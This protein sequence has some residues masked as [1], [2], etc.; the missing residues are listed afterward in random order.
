MRRAVLTW[1]NLTQAYPVPPSVDLS[2]RLTADINTAF[3]LIDIENQDYQKIVLSGVLNV[4]GLNYP[5]ESL[6][7]PLKI[8][9]LN[10]EL[11]PK[12]IEISEI[13]GITGSTD[14]SAVGELQ[15]TLGFL[16]NDGVLK[17]NFEMKSNSFVIEDLMVEG[18]DNES[19]IAEEETFK[20]P[21]YLDLNLNA[22]VGKAVYDNVVM[23]D[24]VGNLR[25]KDEVITF[26]EISSRMLDGRLVFDG[27]VS[28]KDEKPSFRMALDMTR[29]NIANTFESIE[30]MQLLSPAAKALDGRFST[31]M[32]L[33]GNLTDQLDLDINSISGDVL[34]E[35]LTAEMSPDRAPVTKLLDNTLGF[36]VLDKLD[37]SG[38][39]TAFSFKDGQVQV[40][41]FTVK[42]EDIS[43]ELSGGHS[44]ANALDYELTLDVPARYMGDDVNK[45]LAGIGDESLEGITVPV[46]ANIAGSYKEPKISTDLKS[47]VRAVTNQLVEI[48]KQKYINKGKK[49]VNKLIG[50]MLTGNDENDSNSKD[51]DNTS[52]QTAH[53]IEKTLQNNSDSSKKISTKGS[54][55]KAVKETAKSILGG[56]LKSKSITSK[57]T[58]N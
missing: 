42:Y 29:L 18:S 58:L 37:L 2:G 53:I 31:K 40:K 25:I 43:L 36:V 45:L 15:N 54:G 13:A 48:Q 26:S 57:D 6:P 4:T 35:I 30:L 50:N 10:A 32:A 56:L 49:E 21:T 28:T 34:A 22:L 55:D 8:H 33:A 23:Y 20:I 3:T 38:L 27:L 16:F 46:I 52:V 47:Q 44:F 12:K 41:P 17:G 19:E 14:F 9:T 7:H 24:L 5:F 51:D 39:K 1:D 11:G